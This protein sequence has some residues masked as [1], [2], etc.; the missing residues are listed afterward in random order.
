MARWGGFTRSLSESFGSLFEQLRDVRFPALR[1]WFEGDFDRLLN[2]LDSQ[3]DWQ[4]ANAIVLFLY[5]GAPLSR[6]RQARWKEIFEDNWYP[7]GPSEKKSW[8]ESRQRITPEIKARIERIRNLVIRDFED[9]EYLFPSPIDGSGRPIASVERMWRRA[10]V[11]LNYPPYPLRE[12]GLRR[13]EPTRPS[14][15]LSF[16]RQYGP[17]LRRVQNAAKVSKIVTRRRNSPAISASCDVEH[18]TT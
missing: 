17:M 7:Y 1:A 10:L 3:A 9:S 12:V 11:A 18:L 6:V 13:R 4:S 8:F 5:W 15:W 2:F 14:Y 16:L